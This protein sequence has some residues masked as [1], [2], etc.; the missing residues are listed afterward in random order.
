MISKTLNSS[1]YK[2]TRAFFTS[3]LGR[4]AVV[5]TRSCSPLCS[6]LFFSRGNSTTISSDRSGMKSTDFLIWTL[7]GQRDEEAED[8]GIPVSATRKPCHSAFKAL[9]Q[10]FL[11]PKRKKELKNKILSLIFLCLFELVIENRAMRGLP[12]ALLNADQARHLF[13]KCVLNIFSCFGLLY[14]Q[15]RWVIMLDKQWRKPCPFPSM[16]YLS[17]HSPHGCL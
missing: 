8:Q 1:S 17:K 2:L 13:Y 9:E 6:A 11:T 4:R 10:L 15:F 7:P 14:V 5:F 3:H 12:E 16:W